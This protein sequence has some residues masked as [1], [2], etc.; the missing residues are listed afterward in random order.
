M[1]PLVAT[2][3]PVPA[4]ETPI[5]DTALPPET[6]APVP[7]APTAPAM[8]FA[9]TGDFGVGDKGPREVSALVASWNPAFVITTG[10]NYYPHAGGQGT[11]EYDA[12]VGAFYGD[13]LKDISTT[14]SFCPVGRASVN[15]FF[16]SLGNHDYVDGTPNTYLTYFDLPGAGFK[17]SSGNER[18]YDFIEG[19]IHFFVLNSNAEEPDGVSETSKQA[20]WL[21]TQLRRSKSRWNIVYDHHPPYC[22]DTH[23]GSTSYMEWPFAKWG[24]DVVISGH[25]HVYERIK[26]DGIVY[27]VNGVGGAGRYSFGTPVQ[28][29]VVRYNA[30]WGAQKVTATDK[31]LHFQFIN[32]GGV[33]VDGC[34][35][36]PK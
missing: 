33:V 17:N 31:S 27:F 29:S 13:W 35:L 7:A 32:T 21:H 16:P 22:S 23:R 14:G 12:S 6:A 11:G 28:G 25:G 9:V 18:Y 30:G 5:P 24:A 2:Q 36:R 34:W 4:T 15:A 3:T 1:T 19:P 20:Q 8:T 10:D 26:R